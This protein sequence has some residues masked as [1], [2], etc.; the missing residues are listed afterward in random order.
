MWIGS[1]FGPCRSIR[2]AGQLNQVCADVSGSRLG[3]IGMNCSELVLD[4]LR[5]VGVNS[6]DLFNFVNGV[7]DS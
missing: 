5:L 7:K 2:H 3:R 6:K 4:F 1:K